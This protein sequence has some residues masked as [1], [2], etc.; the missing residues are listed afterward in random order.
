MGWRIKEESKEGEYGH[1]CTFYMKNKYRK[2][3]SVEITIKK[4]T[5]TKLEG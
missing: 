1:W 3:I 5:E 2:L 4:E